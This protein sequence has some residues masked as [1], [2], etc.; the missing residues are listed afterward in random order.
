MMA[1]F[2]DDSAP[3]YLTIGVF[4]AIIV[5]YVWKSRKLNAESQSDYESSVQ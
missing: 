5:L 3:W 2:G 4:I 1:A